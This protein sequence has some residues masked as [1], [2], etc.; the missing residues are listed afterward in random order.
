MSHEK[1]I[2]AIAKENLKEFARKTCKKSGFPVEA[3]RKPLTLSPLT[4]EGR[5]GGESYQAIYPLPQP[6]P[7]VEGCFHL[8]PK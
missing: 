2:N 8:G 3:E 1:D 6:L 5:G 7:P 4:G